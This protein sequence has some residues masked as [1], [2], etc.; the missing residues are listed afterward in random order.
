MILEPIAL[1][2]F[3]ACYVV[4]LLHLLGLVPLA[5]TVDLGLYGL[6]TLAAVLGWIAGNVYVQRARGLPKQLRRRFLMVYFLGP[7]SVVLM[8]RFMA[9]QAVQLVQPLVPAYALG[10]FTIFF[11]VPVTLRGSPP[12]RRPGREDPP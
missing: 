1:A 2:L 7:V 8:L 9:P 3:L 6:Y 12:R 4:A 11:L 10:V 5:G